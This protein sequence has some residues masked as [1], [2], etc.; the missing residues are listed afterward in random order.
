[1]TKVRIPAKRALTC[2]LQLQAT[3]MRNQLAGTVLA[4]LGPAPKDGA[5]GATPRKNNAV[6]LLFVGLVFLFSV[7]LSFLT[8][9]SLRQDLPERLQEKG[10][11]VARVAPKVLTANVSKPVGPA[12]VLRTEP[13]LNAVALLF[14]VWF[15]T[16]VCVSI[17]HQNKEI[18][19]L[20][21]DVEWLLTLPVSVPVIYAG[22]VV[23]R[24]L[25]SLGWLAFTPLY[26]CVLWFWGYRWTMP[27]MAIGLTL[28]LN[29]LAAVTQFS[30]EVFFR[31]FL[32]AYALNKVQAAATLLGMASFFVAGWFFFAESGAT[33]HRWTQAAGSAAAYLPS[34]I[35]LTMLQAGS[36]G[37][38]APRL[39]I[40]LAQA[41]LVVV[42]GWGLIEWASR[43][44]LEAVQPPH[45]G[46]Q[47]R[48]ATTSRT[49]FTGVISKDLLMLRRDSRLL[50]LLLMP[51]LSLTA[52]LFIPGFLN[53]AIQSPIQWGT[54]AFA[55]GIW[56]LLN[57]APGVLLHEEGALWML[58]TVPH[59][60][61]SLI[62]RKALVWIAVAL[63]TSLVM[64]GVGIS[65]RGR[66]Q[67]QDI[68]AFGWILFGVPLYGMLCVSVGVRGTDPLR[69][70]KRRR[71]RE[72][73]LAMAALFGL[74]LTA[75]LQ[76]PGPWAKGRCLVMFAVLVIAWWQQAIARLDYLL[77][78]A[79]LP[80]RRI[81]AADGL[82]A[83]ILFFL[84]QALFAILTSYL[85]GLTPTTSYL[86]AYVV[87]A[88]I[89]LAVLW[90]TLR[91]E[92]LSLREAL[93]LLKRGE[94][95]SQQTATAVVAGVL[96]A[97]VIGCLYFYLSPAQSLD[98]LQLPRSNWEGVL[99]LVVAPVIAVILQPC[100]DELIHCGFVFQGFRRSMTFLMAA[101]LSAIMLALLQPSISIIPMFLI[102]I[103]TA[104]AYEKSAGLLAP[105]L[106]RAAYN[107]TAV[108]LQI[109]IYTRLR[110]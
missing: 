36:A 7:G 31:R 38:A 82:T 101:A 75:G 61:R 24:T 15:T 85:P 51:W 81:H 90:N 37:A 12:E 76:L 18:S 96:M 68:E 103:V 105:I 84:L 3:K 77:D 83:L 23:E 8:V 94:K 102:G 33:T 29:L 48:R 50:A 65:Y 106:V 30:L 70:E 34:A 107:A 57:T 44:G 59:S 109:V 100:V 110:G 63:V 4:R 78:P 46:T 66:L 2:I 88:L 72:D 21:A 67:Q 9:N 60:L 10:G 97:L 27:L 91:L 56:P 14:A 49:M 52:L 89:A 73:V 58:Y 5:R 69:G 47:E 99:V 53:S 32:S 98:H 13:F 86:L 1:M 87:A 79:A 6:P 64:L 55:F 104:W 108:L 11:A 54:L 40:H 41:G 93:P 22:K 19:R 39:L 16:V 80:P 71:L 95:E 42:G 20:G 43:R 92:G 26:G 35:A 62:L 28:V 25:L 74:L 45:Q 17:G